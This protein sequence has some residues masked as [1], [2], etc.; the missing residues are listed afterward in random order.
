[1]ID[2]VARAIHKVHS[3]LGCDSKSGAETKKELDSLKQKVISG[4]RKDVRKVRETNTTLQI[5]LEKGEFQVRIIKPT[6]KE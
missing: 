5:L 2:I 3:L 1:M 4:K 6:K